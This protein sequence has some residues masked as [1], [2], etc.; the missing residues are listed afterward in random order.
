MMKTPP[1]I[2]IIVPAYNVEKFLGKTLDSILAQTL[3]D[4]NALS[5]TTVPRTVR[6][7]LHKA[8]LLVTNEYDC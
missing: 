5:L 4:G 7:A 1:L 3:N 2:S 6:V 8:M